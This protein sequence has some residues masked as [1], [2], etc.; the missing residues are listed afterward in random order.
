M[1]HIFPATRLFLPRSLQDLMHSCARPEDIPSLL[2]TSSKELPDFV[3]ELSRLEL[4]Q[5]TC[6]QSP[7]PQREGQSR[8]INPSLQMVSTSW[9]G[10]TALVEAT[11]RG[12]R[13]DP[14]PGSENILI[15]KEPQKGQVV[16][17][18]ATQDDF[19][20]LKIAAEGL[21]PQSVALEHG[22]LPLALNS[23][24]ARVEQEGLIIA[25]ASS[26]VRDVAIV[27]PEQEWAWPQYARA[28]VFTLQWHVTQACDLR[29]RHC[30]DR[31]QRR[32]MPWGQALDVLDMFQAFCDHH[33][34]Q[35]QI[36]FTGGNPLLYP[37]FSSLYQEASRRGFI[38]AILG[39]PAQPDI[40]NTLHTIQ[41]LA[42]Y[43]I[44]LEGLQEHNDWIRGQGHFE[45]SL[46]FLSLLQ[47]LH[48]PSQVM[49]TLTRD[50]IHQILP[51]ARKLRGRTERFTFNRLSAVGEGASLHLPDKETYTAFMQDYLEAATE[52]PFLRLKDNLLNVQGWKEAGEVFGGCTGF[53]CGAAFNFI[54]LLPDGEVHA[55][56]KF[57]SWIGTIQ[58]SDLIDIYAGE[59]A[60]GY[61]QGPVQCLGCSLRPVCGGCLA[62]ISSAGLDVHTDRDPYCPLWG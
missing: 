50:N 24:L 43:Q 15:W 2:E 39:N 29:C 20:A 34:V 53:G 10:L 4:A 22:L 35:G 7:Q 21:H 27:S 49:L 55:C 32:H 28:S 47:D 52:M 9:T 12:N 36:T 26:I 14:Q 60:A 16:T 23:L 17:K 31:S 57:P 54:S 1:Q 8:Q 18:A 19:L 58:D 33:H 13:P 44:S 59:L 30:Y 38:L 40:V 51:L 48:I 11:K 42:F 25:P 3:P 62:V 5:Y 46:H 37:H 45:R 6:S 41:P 56:R 61:R